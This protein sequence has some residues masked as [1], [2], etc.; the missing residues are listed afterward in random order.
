[1][2]ADHA[3]APYI[4]VLVGLTFFTVLEIIWALPSVGLGRGLLIGGLALMAGIKAAMV[5]LY[6]M[7][8]KWEGRVIWGVIAFPIILV[9][10]MVA[11]LIV[12]AFHYY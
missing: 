12:D 10:V 5:G 3:N 11:G 8:L 9:V 2:S 1:M 4:K 7:H 6:Y